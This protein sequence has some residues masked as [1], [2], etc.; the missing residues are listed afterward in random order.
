L[1]R[2]LIKLNSRDTGFN[3]ASVL[4]VRLEPKG[5]DQKRGANAIRLNNL[6]QGL[7][8]RVLAIP[9]V[10]SASLAGITPT[11]AI[12]P[13]RTIETRSGAEVGFANVQVYP[14]YFQTMG[15]AI[16][17]GRDFDRRDMGE[18]ASRVAVINET[19]ARAAFPNSN[20]VGN[21]F[22]CEGPG[23]P[24]CDV[25]GVVADERY[26]NL[27]GEPGAV[28]YQPFLQRNTGRGQMVLYVRSSGNSTGV[29]EQ[30]KAA[31]Q[32][33]DQ[34]LPAF[35]IHTLRA[36]IDAALAPERLVGMLTGLFSLLALLL[37]AI[38]LYGVVAYTAMRKTHEIGIRMALG[39]EKR[40]VLRMV[41]GQGLRHALIGVAAGVAGGL[42]L[43][44]FLASMLYG[45]KPTDPLTFMVVS[46]ILIAV[47]LLACYIPA[48]RAARVDPMVALRY[49]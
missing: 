38:G 18:N 23:K 26:S 40:D 10:L 20:P 1:L 33:M 24:N 43:T 15:M 4:V 7:Q 16:L 3:R 14:Q 47:A 34:N 39:A 42:G 27:R 6:Y 17:S 49:E 5:S 31:V 11:A 29:R 25:I 30:V 12:R 36:E 41:V 19:L 13:N 21:Q 35:N 9:G 48:R 44:Q 28:V 37:A 32:A 46:L 22:E 2:S 8:D 45:I